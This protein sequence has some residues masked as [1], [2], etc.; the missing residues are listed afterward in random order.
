ML[1]AGQCLGNQAAMLDQRRTPVKLFKGGIDVG[2]VLAGNDD[3]IGGDSVGEIVDRVLKGEVVGHAVDIDAKRLETA[4]K[5][6]EA[7]TRT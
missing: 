7:R 2:D 4:L 3:V 5:R 6:L 1:G